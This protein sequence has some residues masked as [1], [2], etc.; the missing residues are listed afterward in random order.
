MFCYQ[1]QEA[2]QGIG[3]T[4]RGVCG[5]TYDVANLQDLLIFTLKGI[6]FLNFD[7][8]YKEIFRNGRL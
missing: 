4:V 1:C 2:S 8:S 3:C 7:R 5:K 6:S